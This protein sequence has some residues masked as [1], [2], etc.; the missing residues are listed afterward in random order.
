MARAS[1]SRG[2]EEGLF[3][4]EYLYRDASNFKI[5]GRAILSGA[6]SI[7]DLQPHLY[8][9]EFFLPELVGLCRLTP[10][11]MTN[12]DHPWHELGGVQSVSSGESLMGAG[13]L[14]SRFKLQSSLTW[15]QWTPASQ[16]GKAQPRN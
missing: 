3:E 11:T 5:W 10:A 8:E 14:V 16:Y 4:L 1:K 9:G 2:S 7:R 12:D 6:L 13:E 15:G